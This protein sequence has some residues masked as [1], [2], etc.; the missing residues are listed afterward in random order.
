MSGWEQE[1]DGRHPEGCTQQRPALTG[2][3]CRANV[4]MYVCMYVQMCTCADVHVL[5]GMDMG[6]DMDIDMYVCIY[7][8]A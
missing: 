2:L 6:M 5:V 7:V 4:D 8:Y 1:V 3:E